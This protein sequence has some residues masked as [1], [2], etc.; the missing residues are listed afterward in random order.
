MSMK[1]FAG[2]LLHRDSA[3]AYLIIGSGLL[4]AL[5]YAFFF[6]NM[7]PGFAG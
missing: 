7:F 5:A 3:V 6:P 4:L 1:N 2:L